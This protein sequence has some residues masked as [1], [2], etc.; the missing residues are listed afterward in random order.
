MNPRMILALAAALG[1]SLPGLGIAPP[2]SGHL[3]RRSCPAFN[4]PDP[5]PPPLPLADQERIAAARAK[6]ERKAARLAAILG[7]S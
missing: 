4:G 3:S 2:P 7:A 6:R 5:E 1:P